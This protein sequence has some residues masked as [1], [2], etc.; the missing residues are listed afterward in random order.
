[1]PTPQVD[2]VA[3]FDRLPIPTLLMTP[4]LVIVD[5]NKAYE[6][7]SGRSRDE[8]AGQQVLEAFPENPSEPAAGGPSDLAESL[9]RVIES[10]EP[11]VMGLQ[12]YDVEVPSVPG[13]FKERYWCPMNVPVVDPDGNVTLIIHSVEEVS[14]LIRKFVEAQAAS[15]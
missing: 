6:G 13:V 5:A 4:D 15:A 8:L 7:I 10:G 9:R 14:D 11:D 12:R 1:M 3:V 2:Y